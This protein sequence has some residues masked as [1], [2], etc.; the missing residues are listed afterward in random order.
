MDDR[1][2]VAR[3]IEDTQRQA[4][5]LLGADLPTDP[6]APRWSISARWIQFECGCAGER[7]MELHHPQ[8]WDPII[9]QGTPQQAVYAKV[10]DRHLPGMNVRLGFGRDSRGSQFVDFAHWQRSRRAVL[11]GRV[12]P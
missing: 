6:W 10:C 12:R 1:S 8:P 7:C 11:M 5:E 3:R 4:G 2:Q 9:F